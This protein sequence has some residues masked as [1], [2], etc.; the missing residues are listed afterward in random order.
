MRY[1]QLVYPG[2]AADFAELFQG[3]FEATDDILRDESGDLGVA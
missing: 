1:S 3:G 2:S